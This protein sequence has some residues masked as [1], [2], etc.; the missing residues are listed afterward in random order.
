MLAVNMADVIS[1]VKSVAPHLVA[2]ATLFVAAIIVMFI[3]RKKK[4]A[5][6]K[7]AR[8]VSWLIFGL[9]TLFSINL[10]LNGPLKTMIT[11]ATGRGVITEESLN[12]AKTLGEEISSEGIVLLK[13][14]SALP[15]EKGS[16]INLFGWSSRLAFWARSTSAAEST[17]S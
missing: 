15:L 10:M 5:F 7:L 3:T 12:E 14:D 8:S 13:N 16:K 11:L 9:G 6:K 1:V 4:T 2:I 17:A